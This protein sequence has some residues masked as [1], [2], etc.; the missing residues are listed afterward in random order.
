VADEFVN[1][2]AWKIRGISR[3]P[4]KASSKAWSSKGVEMVAGDLD[5]GA[6]LSNAFKGANVIFGVTDFWQ[7]FWNPEFQKIAAETGKT[8]NQL[9]YDME[10]RQGKMIVDAANSTIGTL[11]MLILSTIYSATQGSKGKMKTIYHFDAKWDAVEY[12]KITY[13]DLYKKTSLYQPAVYLSNWRN[14][15]VT[16]P[17]KQADGTYILR[18]PTKPDSKI[19]M[20]DPRVDSGEL[21]SS[22]II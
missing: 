21:S 3:D 19:P 7:G 12:T 14:G 11:D 22:M 16:A 17:R 13:P 5:D 18:L 15:G 6:S 1:D 8:V 2:P 4:S 10:V 20:I 9:C